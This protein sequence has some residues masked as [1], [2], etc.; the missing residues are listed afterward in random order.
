MLGNKCFII[1]AAGLLSFLASGAHA[2]SWIYNRN[3]GI[4]IYQPEGWRTGQ[5]GRLTELRGPD[6][7]IAQSLILVGS[8]WDSKVHNLND[9]KIFMTKTTGFANLTPIKISGLSGFQGG[10]RQNGAR[11]VLRQEQN[12][13]ELTWS[14]R[15]TEPQIQEGLTSISSVDVRS[16]IDPSQNQKSSQ[17]DKSNQ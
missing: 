10:H 5:Q 6:T 1:W 14:L 3:S 15:G 11:F 4:G 8:D 2:G 17:G 7:D 13:I 16:E 12:I 9:L